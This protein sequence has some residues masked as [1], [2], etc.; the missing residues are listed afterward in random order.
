M[1]LVA[2]GGGAGMLWGGHGVKT[3]PMAATPRARPRLT[4]MGKGGRA[5][6]RTQAAKTFARYAA[7]WAPPPKHLPN[8]LVKGQLNA[9]DTELVQQITGDP[10]AGVRAGTPYYQV[11]QE[12]KRA[13]ERA[14]SRENIP[15][16]M[17]HIVRDYFE[18][19]RP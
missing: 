9:N 19:I 2:G 13:A 8:A 17:Q 10:N 18:R 11:Y 12:Q 4:L 14:V 1:R 15:P 3:N 6:T 7:Q 16:E 5:S